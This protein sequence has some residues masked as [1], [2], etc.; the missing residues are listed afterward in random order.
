MAVKLTFLGTSDQIP[1]KK[2]NH[3]AMLLTYDGENILI[4]C[5]EGTQR[6]FRRANINMCKI[7]R[8][9]ITHWHGDHVFGLPGLLSSLALSGYRKTLCI[10]GPKGTKEFM[11]NLLSVFRFTKSYPIEVH[12]IGTGKF[13]DMKD[14]YIEAKGMTHGIP[15]N[16][17]SFVKK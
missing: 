13:L 3:S 17:Y 7:T 15:T 12:E 10:Y 8:I 1:S 6:Q 4:D 16:A 5:G 9:L 11:R 2:R 14:F